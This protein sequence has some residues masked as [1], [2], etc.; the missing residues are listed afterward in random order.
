MREHCG[1]HL[2]ATICLMPE[3]SLQAGNMYMHKTDCRHS[4]LITA[5][6]LIFT[7]VLFI[8]VS[9]FIHIYSIP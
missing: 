6:T 3:R 9:H 1:Q 5:S 7:Q 2:M 4:V 8:I